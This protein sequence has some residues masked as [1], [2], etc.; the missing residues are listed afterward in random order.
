MK[1]ASLWRLLACMLLV[2]LLLPGT[3]CF[4]DKEP[5]VAPSEA[6]NA[7]VRVFSEF[8]DG[9]CATGSAFGV[10]QLGSEPQYFVT[11]AHVV[12]DDEGNLADNVY[13]LLDS[14]AVK[15]YYDEMDYLQD[16]DVNYSKTVSCSVLN[17]DSIALYPDVAV[18]KANKA[19]SGRICLPLRPTSEDAEAAETVYA[20]G[21]PG[22]TDFLTLSKQNS[23]NIVAGVED[24]NVTSGIVSMKTNSE[25]LGG[26]DVILH[27]ATISHGNSGGPLIDENGAVLGV[28]TYAI[29]G[30]E[31]QY[32]SIYVDY[33]IDM[34]DAAKVDYVKA[35]PVKESPVKTGVLLALM[36]LIVLAAVVLVLHFR[37]KGAEFLEEKAR[38]EAKE[39]RVQGLSGYFAGRR[40]PLETQLSIGRA[41]DN[42]IVFPTDTKGVS[43]HHCVLLK[44]NDNLYIKDLGSTNGTVVNGSRRL[45]ENELI[46]I[47]VGDRFAL[48]SEKETFILT[49][50]GGKV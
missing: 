14:K 45:P 6:K 27:S 15:L 5:T 7:V 13:I 1:K 12:L 34:L 48:G 36:A 17:E 3:L 32:V 42:S 22:D 29:P 44:V 20:L 46:S 33:V 37:K 39:L 21:Y 41:P 26:T 25:Y 50:K 38:E 23:L 31:T 49:Y 28:N 35:E 30:N 11:N 8:A 40:F 4:A 16:I 19:I 9:S 18:L 43:A 10:G 47:Q 24:V 2:M